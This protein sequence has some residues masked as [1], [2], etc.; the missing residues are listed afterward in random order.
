[1]VFRGAV[2]RYAKGDADG[3]ADAQ[4][5]ARHRGVPDT[6]IDWP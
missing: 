4:A 5:F 1:M 3:R 6:Q 2:F